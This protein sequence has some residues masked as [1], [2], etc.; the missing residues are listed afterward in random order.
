M[1]FMS[2]ACGRPRG[3]GGQAR[4]NACGQG[5]GGQKP[6]FSQI[7]SL[8]KLARQRRCHLTF[9]QRHVLSCGIS[10]SVLPALVRLDDICTFPQVSTAPLVQYH[11]EKQPIATRTRPN[12]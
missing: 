6:D 4:V 9:D 11:P 3:G 12:T 8:M 10:S 7:D 1:Y 2:M 5:E